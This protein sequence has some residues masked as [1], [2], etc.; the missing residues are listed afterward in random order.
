MELKK[1]N[2]VPERPWVTLTAYLS[3]SRDEH[4]DAL[5]ICPGGGYYNVCDKHEGEAVAI[6]FAARGFRTFV[7]NYS[8]QENA[9]FPTPLADASLA[10]CHIKDHAKEYGIDPDRVFVAGFSAGGHLA[11]SLG[12]LWHK[13]W[14]MRELSIPYGYNKPAGMILSYPV[15]SYFPETHKGTFIHAFGTET[16]TEEM[17]NELSLDKQVDAEH[18]VPAFI[19]HTMDDEL[20]HVENTFRM[21]SALRRYNVYTEAHLFPHGPHGMATADKVIAGNEDIYNDKRIAQW[22][23]LAAD[24]I[25]TLPKK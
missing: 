1:I 24:F 10:I 8:V 11:G 13:E 22:V 18:T 23:D 6:A 25:R 20:V 16:P 19:W 7:L 9:K 14:L 2:L 12:T 5:L 4:A 21:I 15:I 17:A 3:Y